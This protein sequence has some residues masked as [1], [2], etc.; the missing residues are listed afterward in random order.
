MGAL[1]C[2]CR[3]KIAHG[4]LLCIAP[5]TAARAALLEQ[6]P[7]EGVRALAKL[8]RGMSGGDRWGE[9]EVAEVIELFCRLVASSRC[10]DGAVL[11][12]L[13]LAIQ[14]NWGE[15]AVR[16]AVEE[17]GMLEVA[18]QSMGAEEEVVFVVLEVV[19]QV[20]EESPHFAKPLLGGDSMAV[21]RQLLSSSQPQI[22]LKA[23]RFLAYILDFAPLPHQILIHDRQ[24]SALL[25]TLL[26]TDR[27][28]IRS[29]VVLLLEQA[30]ACF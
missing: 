23:C 21:V 11:S 18:L 24:L 22:R 4:A 27:P 26:Q 8:L 10:V 5:P 6:H 12:H 3:L 28:A 17:Y 25:L 9:G 15:E 13:C 30:F 7:R 19:A 20:C 2:L 16:R 14:E 29:E 1:R